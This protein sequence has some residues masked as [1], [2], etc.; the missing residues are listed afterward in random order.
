M[1]IAQLFVLTGV[2]L[3]IQLQGLIQFLSESFMLAGWKLWEHEGVVERAKLEEML[4]EEVQGGEQA[5]ELDDLVL[6]LRVVDDH[7][8][9]VGQW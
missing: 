3:I 4:W 8:G 9:E 2:A 1:H 5:A 6:E 7:V